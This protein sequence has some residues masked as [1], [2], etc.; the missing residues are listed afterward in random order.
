MESKETYLEPLLHKAEEYSKASFEILKLKALD[1]SASVTSAIISRFILS[2]VLS[3]FI[4]SLNIALA[5]WLGDLL[6]KD[7]YGFLLV[8]GFYG[9]VS[10]VLFSM[11]P[12]I[13]TSISNIIISQLLN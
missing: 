3:F 6:G 13:K 9:L 2:L 10:I 8:A 11:H 12:R 7:Y 5:L 4:L 1:K